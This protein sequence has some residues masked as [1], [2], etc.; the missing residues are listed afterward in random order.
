MNENLDV[1]IKKTY[2]SLMNALFE[3]AEQRKFE[4]ITVN[5]LCDVAMVGRGTFYKHFEDKYQFFSFVAEEMLDGYME[6]A[7]MEMDPSASVTYYL[8][9]FDAFLSFYERINQLFGPLRSGSTVSMV[10]HTASETFS[11]HLQ[12]QLERDSEAGHF[13]YISSHIGACFLTGAMVRS[14]RLLSD[15]PGETSREE[16]VENMK[17]LLEELY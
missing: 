12:E 17:I 14:A 13:P 16:I 8:S 15:H 10:L 2:R 5:D 9:C 3:L 6:R 11:G 4:D 7:E 1:R